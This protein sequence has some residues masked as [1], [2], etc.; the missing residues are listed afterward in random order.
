MY[1]AFQAYQDD[2]QFEAYL[3]AKQ[4]SESSVIAWL[5]ESEKVCS[6]EIKEVLKKEID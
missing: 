6:Q 3:I 5:K 1:N 2:K 4:N